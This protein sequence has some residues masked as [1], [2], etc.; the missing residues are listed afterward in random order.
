MVA[1]IFCV[2]TNAKAVIE[3]SQLDEGKR[4]YSFPVKE[5]KLSLCVG[6]TVGGKAKRV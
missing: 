5:A 4:G 2:R 3:R 6:D 1:A